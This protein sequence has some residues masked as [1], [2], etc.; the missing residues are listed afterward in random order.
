MRRGS[1]MKW[2]PQNGLGAAGWPD[3][4]LYQRSRGFGLHQ[5]GFKCWLHPLLN[6]AL[7]RSLDALSLSFLIGK[8]RVGTQRHWLLCGW[9]RLLS[10]PQSCTC[11]GAAHHQGRWAPVRA[12]EVGR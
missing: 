10:E 9:N 4:H 3:T 1:C 12:G 7:G 5:S 11:R 8:S 2:G 6:T